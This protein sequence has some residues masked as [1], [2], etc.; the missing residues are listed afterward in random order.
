MSYLSKMHVRGNLLD[1]GCGFGL[2]LNLA[3]GLGF[4]VKGIDPD[5][6]AI[7]EARLRYNVSVYQ[8]T[9]EEFRTKEKFDVIIFHHV[10]EHIADPAQAVEKS[11]A[12]LNSNGIVIVMVPN[13]KGILKRLGLIIKS[14]RLLDYLYVPEDH[15][16]HFDHTNLERLFIPFGF[17]VEY[18]RSHVFMRTS[19]VFKFIK[20]REKIAMHKRVKDRILM[21]LF[22]VVLLLI[23]ITVKPF[24]SIG[25]GDHLLIVF[26]LKR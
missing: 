18:S 25:L 8:S 6:Q 20:L 14:K 24:D 4:N 21:Y 13:S 1:V 3:R 10:L 23:I 26:R 17:K 11:A 15:F 9:I 5:R 16:W 12:L 19:S 2:L 7:H 22:M